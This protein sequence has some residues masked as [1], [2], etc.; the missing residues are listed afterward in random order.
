M[1]SPTKI[2]IKNKKVKQSKQNKNWLHLKMHYEIY[3]IILTIY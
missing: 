2:T 3:H 1:Q